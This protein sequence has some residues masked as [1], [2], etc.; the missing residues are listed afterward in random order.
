[1][2]AEEFPNT[3][4]PAR[5]LLVK[6]CCNDPAYKAVNHPLGLMSIAAYLRGKYGCQAKII[7]LRLDGNS[8]SDWDSEIRLYAPD[9]VGISALTFESDA[10]PWIAESVKRVNANTPVL[11]GGPHATAYPEQAA[12]I[13]GIDYVIVGEGEVAA[14]RLIERIL[15]RRDLSGLKGIVYKHADRVVMTGR[16]DPIEDINLLPAPA[17]DLIPIEQYGSYS[18]MSRTGSGKFMSLFSSRGCP[19]QC[20][21]CHN[22]FGKV[23][24]F[25]SAE[26]LLTKSDTFTQPI[27]SEILKFW[28]TSSISTG[29]D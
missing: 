13:P 7:D 15:S 24:R 21:Y 1:M 10:I 6:S 4:R 3:A 20:I 18:R 12:Q 22:I 8:R 25:R 29:I 16:E 23:F 11:L 2:R 27:R 26:G 9:I 14:G 19:Y 17:Y 28:T 5:I